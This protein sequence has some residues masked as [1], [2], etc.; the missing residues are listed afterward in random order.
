MKRIIV[1]VITATVLCMIASCGRKDNTEKEPLG[2][3]SPDASTPAAT[4]GQA[5]TGNEDD[6]ANQTYIKSIV[7]EMSGREQVLELG[8]IDMQNRPAKLSVS[9]LATDYAQV[10]DG[11]YY[12]LKQDRSGQ[13]I[14]LYR[15]KGEKVAK[16][17]CNKEREVIKG[18][19]LEGD[20]LYLFC[21][22]REILYNED[23]YVYFIKCANIKTGA[24]DVIFL[25]G[26]YSNDDNVY[27]DGYHYY[28]NDYWIT[29][30]Y[31]YG[32]YNSSRTWCRVDRSTGVIDDTF[33]LHEYDQF[34]KNK[35]LIDGKI[36][37]MEFEERTP[38]HSRAFVQI[39]LE[40]KKRRILFKYTPQMAGAITLE[41]INEEGIY[42]WEKNDKEEALYKIPLHDGKIEKVESYASKRHSLYKNHLVYIDKKNRMHVVNRK[43]KTDTVI[44]N[45]FK[46]SFTCAKEGIFMMSQDAD[47]LEI[48]INDDDGS[49]YMWNNALSL[50]L[51]YMDYNG[52]NLTQLRKE[53]GP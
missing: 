51:Y 25:G 1:F 4:S 36:Y 24:V 11:H 17:K 41:E 43:K 53:V 23:V 47:W 34:V 31:L 28:V 13:Y 10:K 49:G 16:I 33:N 14:V 21:H 5:V 39:D 27:Y 40:K 44:K 29:E 26:K 12:Y 50:P 8:W 42:I 7:T 52:E 35:M 30:K 37:Y 6:H 3:N 20:I 32:Y 45:N 18:A 9:G 2:S 48:E 19:T 38:D 15:D 46:G 22:D